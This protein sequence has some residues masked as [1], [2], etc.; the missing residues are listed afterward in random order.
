MANPLPLQ[1]TGANNLVVAVLVASWIN[2]EGDMHMKCGW[3]GMSVRK[4]VDIEEL[5]VTY[6]VLDSS[7]LFR[8]EK[9]NSFEKR[10]VVWIGVA[11]VCFIDAEFFKR[12]FVG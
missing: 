5:S 10:T 7:F 12:E 3:P 6:I 1:K 11:D 8:L 9:A 2:G 4:N